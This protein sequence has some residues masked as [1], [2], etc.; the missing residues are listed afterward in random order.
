M[1]DIDQLLQDTLESFEVDDSIMPSEW[2]E[3]YRM[4]SGYASE[5]GPMSF[6]RAPFQVE[7]INSIKQHQNI[8]F[9][10]SAQ[11]GATELVT[12]LIGYIVDTAKTPTP[13]MM[14]HATTK[15]AEKYVIGISRSLAY[16]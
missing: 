6:K 4:L 10:K 13:T 16:F 1:T 9:M 2:A 11:V 7:I 3:R 5:P 8:C 12:T 15:S 14:I